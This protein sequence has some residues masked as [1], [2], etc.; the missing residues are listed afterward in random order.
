V[1]HRRPEEN[2]ERDPDDELGQRREREHQHRARVVERPVAP[3]RGED[4]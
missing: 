3:P 1:E 2:D 4:A